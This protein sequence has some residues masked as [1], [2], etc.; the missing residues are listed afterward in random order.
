MPPS[1]ESAPA[2]V[3]YSHCDLSCTMA[4]F[5]LE[6]GTEEL[7][8]DFA[9]LA[10]PQLEAIVQAGLAEARLAHRGLQIRGTPRR[11]AVLVEGLVERQ[12]DARQE[13]KGP[14]A[15]SHCG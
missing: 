4:T 15:P 6:I 7:P 11:L 13:H 1:L 5:L 12:S 10:L 3:A 8:A 2:V 14:P 9:R